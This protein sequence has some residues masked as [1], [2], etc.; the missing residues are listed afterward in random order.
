MARYNF[1]V[2]I[3]TSYASRVGRV[4]GVIAAFFFLLAPPAHSQTPADYLHS[5]LNQK[6]I[7]ARGG[8]Q[9]EVKVKKDNLQRLPESCVMAV[10]VKKAE[11]DRG[12][13]RFWLQNIGTPSLA[14]WVHASSGE[15]YPSCKM[16]YDQIRLEITDFAHDE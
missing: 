12:K 3:V 7:L 10:Q 16:Y 4:A 6:L 14:G 11:W 9:P 1:A 2:Q 15:H 8:D 5:L 13:A